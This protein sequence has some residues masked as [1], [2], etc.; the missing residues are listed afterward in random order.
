MKKLA[1]RYDNDLEFLGSI[2]SEDLETLVYC[3]THDSDGSKRYTEELTSSDGYKRHKPNHRMY[4][5]DIAAEVQCFGA[6]TFATM[7]RGGKGVTYK[8]VLLDV[9]SKFDVPCNQLMS[10]DGIENELLLRFFSDA[11]KRMTPEELREFADAA[12]VTYSSTISPEI[13]IG[14][15]QAIFKAGGFKSYQMT[16]VI[17][18]AVLK[19][20]IGRGLP[21]AMAGSMMQA[22]K[23]LTG[24][25]GWTITAIWTA[26]DV[27]GPAYRV[28]VPAVIQ[29]AALR[30]KHLYG[31]QLAYSG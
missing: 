14:A 6:N 21:F 29:V 28:T 8:E 26:I 11:F 12:G 24:P 23:V 9:C 30:Q 27:A 20:I 22:L 2:D 17:V 25:V 7:L 3:L 13:M 16:A 4:W 19:A 1:Y 10:I 15:F 5:K 31:N 18:N